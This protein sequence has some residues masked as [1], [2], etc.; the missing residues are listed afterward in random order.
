MKGNLSQ[1]HP[2]RCT[3]RRKHDLLSIDP[4]RDSAVVRL[5]LMGD[6]RPVMVMDVQ[7]QEASH[8]WLP[9]A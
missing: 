3:V 7:Y 6:G 8:G 2:S 4:A 5:R 1:A 9:R